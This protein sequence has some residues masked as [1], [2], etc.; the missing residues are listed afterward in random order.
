MPGLK[1]Y[2]VVSCHVERLLDDE[3]WAAFSRLQERVPSGFRIAALI[4]PPDEPAGEDAEEWLLRARRAAARG[5]LGHHTHWGGQD[6]ARPRGGDPAERVLREG[7]WLRAA[8][9][10]P[11]LFCGG[12]WYLDGGV[13][14]AAAELGYADCTATAFRPRYLGADAPRLDAREPC[15]IEL[16][17]GMRLLELPTT[18]TLGM[19]ARGVLAPRGLDF[20]VVH[21]YFHDADLLDRRRSTALTAALALLA[22]RRRPT[23]LDRLRAELDDATL[24]LLPFG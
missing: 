12:G 17:N 16:G 1:R 23:D 7:E 19:L 9:L 6:Q 20:T 24:P 15:R 13:A 4:R 8:G 22:R 5:P 21:A 10:R 11:T 2:A 3:V 14:A 18:H